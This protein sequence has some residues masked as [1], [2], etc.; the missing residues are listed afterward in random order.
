MNCIYC[1]NTHTSSSC[2]SPPTP[3]EKIVDDAEDG[4]HVEQ[5]E[6]GHGSWAIPIH[7]QLDSEARLEDD[8]LVEISISL[9]TSN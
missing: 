9:S 4:G 5:S 7:T 6:E 1:V 2:R 3:E 8:H